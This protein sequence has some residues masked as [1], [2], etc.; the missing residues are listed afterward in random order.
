MSDSS[1]LITICICTY[2]RY[3]VLPK[4][5]ES[6]ARQ[7][8]PMNRY[9]ILVI[10]NSP[11]V[12]GAYSFGGRFNFVPNLE[13]VVERT[14]GLSNARNVAARRC[15]APVLA[16]M[17]DDAIASPDWAAEILEAFDRFGPT[18]KVVGGRVDPIWAA[19][20]PAWLHDSM[21][22]NLSVVN[23]GGDARVADDGEWLA[24]TNIAFRVVDIIEQGGF[25][26]DLGRIGSGSSLLSNEETQLL[27]RLMDAGGRVIYAPRARVE[28]LVETKRMTRDW[29]R[30]RA[31]WQ[32]VSDFKMQPEKEIERAKD[33]W[34]S[35]V[36]Y[37]NAAPPFERTVRGLHFETEDPEMFNWQVGAMY[38]VTSL[39]LAGFEGAPSD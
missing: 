13:Y 28:H 21:L 37:F 18:A 1:P 23:W 20:R 34:P 19:P 33:R 4:A 22:G 3:D 30:K 17:D 36:A 16:F 7:A 32:A 26:T 31:A 29:F 11:D 24:G 10:D 38:Q 27:K 35:V 8:L 12:E 39:L 6:A 5:I 15:T 25:S 2:D 14:P 9:R